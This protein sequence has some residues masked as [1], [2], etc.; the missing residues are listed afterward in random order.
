MS[1]DENKIH[2]PDGLI[3]K[4]APLLGSE[5]K[6][7]FLSSGNPCFQSTNFVIEECKPIPDKDTPQTRRYSC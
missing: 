3:D 2:L 4:R 1:A 7:G 6:Q 5:D